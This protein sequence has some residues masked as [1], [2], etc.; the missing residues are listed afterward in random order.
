[1]L[2]PWQ[3]SPASL[4]LSSADEEHADLIVV[5]THQRKGLGRFFLG[6]VAEQVLLDATQDVLVVPRREAPRRFRNV[7]PETRSDEGDAGKVQRL[8]PGGSE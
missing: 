1:V 5:G 4:I 6:S 7:A 3:G 8:H 2:R